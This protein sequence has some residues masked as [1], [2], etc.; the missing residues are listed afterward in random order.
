MNKKRIENNI[1]SYLERTKEDPMHFKDKDIDDIL[2]I[3][4]ERKKVV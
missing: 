4:F 3:I 2:D 1:R